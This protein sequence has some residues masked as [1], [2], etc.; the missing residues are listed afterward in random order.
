M[1]IVVCL[2]VSMMFA[3]CENGNS[4]GN[5]NNNGSNNGSSTDGN[6]P[7]ASVLSK[8]GLDGMSK[9]SGYSGGD[10]NETVG[11]GGIQGLVIVFSG[12]ASTATSVKKYF[13]DN[14]SWEKVQEINGDGGSIIYYHKES[15]GIAYSTTFTESD[16]ESFQL[17]VAREPIE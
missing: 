10:F 6:W 1:T 4:N 2:A 14:S 8:Y 5:G 7:S 15:N 9:P 13:S 3:S 11:A 12:N 16:G 17:V